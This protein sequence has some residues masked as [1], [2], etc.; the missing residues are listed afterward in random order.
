MEFVFIEG[1][2]IVYWMKK[3]KAHVSEIVESYKYGIIRFGGKTGN[4]DLLL[5]IVQCWRACL[6]Y[7]QNKALPVVFLL[8]N[9]VFIIFS[10]WVSSN[11]TQLGR[12]SYS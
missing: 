4:A 3:T 7:D 6:V 10:S 8:R 9:D 5:H 1:I 12:K 2:E 11:Q